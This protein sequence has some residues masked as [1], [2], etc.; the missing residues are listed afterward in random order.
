MLTNSGTQFF[1]LSK[2]LLNQLMLYYVIDKKAL[3][4]IIVTVYLSPPKN[5]KIH[6]LHRNRLP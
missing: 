2:G 3:G 4:E 1:G 5:M 6:E